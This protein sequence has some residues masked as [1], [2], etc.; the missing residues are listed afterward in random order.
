MAM[1]TV[2]QA[3]RVQLI[4]TC[5]QCRINIQYVAVDSFS[6]SLIHIPV[7]SHRASHWNPVYRPVWLDNTA[8]VDDDQK[9]VQTGFWLTSAG[10][11]SLILSPLFVVII[12]LLETINLSCADAKSQRH[13]CGPVVDVK[14]RNCRAW[15]LGEIH[16]SYKDTRCSKE[17]NFLK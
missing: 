12:M 7:C 15:D 10:N 1:G 13:I 11:Y 9:I 14:P 17:I 2:G 8:F 5:T 6:H 4:H 16:A 3:D